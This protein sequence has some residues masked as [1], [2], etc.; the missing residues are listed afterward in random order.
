MLDEAERE[1]RR[2][3]EMRP[4]EGG[5]PF[6]LGLIAARRGEWEEA[7]ALFRE[8]ADRG[9]P[10][11]PILH[12]QAVAYEHLGRLDEAD[13]AWAEANRRAP[14][15]PVILL[16]WAILALRRQEGDAA[17][18]RLQRARECFGSRIPALW[19]WAATRAEA[20]A[21]Q[22]SSALEIA[23]GGVAAFPADQVLGNGLAVLLELT[24]DG[25]GAERLLRAL[26]E[27]DATRPQLSRN[28]GDIC[29]RS[30]RF[31]Q[32]TESYERAV[33]LAPDL[34]D[35]IH[36]RLGNLAFRR[37]DQGAARTHWSRTL[38]LNPRHQLARTNLDTLPAAP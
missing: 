29:Y 18:R 26:L 21:D 23:Q 6:Y 25:E 15:D 11:A 12:N 38:D 1:F 35:E 22:F 36:F 13:A 31:D 4:S 5:A 24:G 19:Y 27:E 8:A 7:L 2:V 10:R 14:D 17:R 28:L 3:R 34:G 16:G 33:R 32:A 37:G 9:G 20:S 30:G